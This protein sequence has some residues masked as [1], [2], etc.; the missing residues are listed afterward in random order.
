[1]HALHLAILNKDRTSLASVCSQHR[2][3]WEFEI[4]GAGELAGWVTEEAD[5]RGFVGVEGLAPGA[6]AVVSLE[7]RSKRDKGRFWRMGERER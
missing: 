5:S 3:G 2:G 7:E 4:E 6:H 1:V